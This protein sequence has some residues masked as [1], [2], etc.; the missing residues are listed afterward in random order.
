MSIVYNVSEVSNYPDPKL[1]RFPMCRNA[2]VVAHSMP[3]RGEELKFL[4][5]RQMTDRLID[6]Q[7]L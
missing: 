3:L 2:V 4:L 6:R 7:N 1:T 5:G